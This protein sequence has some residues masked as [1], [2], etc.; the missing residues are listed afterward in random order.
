[1]T[2]EQIARSG[3]EHALQTALFCWTHLPDTVAVFP[4]LG[5]SLLF[6]VPNGGLRDKITAGK[7]KASGV[8]K[9]VP[10]IFL[11][12]A[13]GGWFGFYIEMKKLGEKPTKEQLEFKKSVEDR[14][15]LWMCFD[16][17]EIARDALMH[18]MTL[19]YTER[20]C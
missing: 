3:T 12:I 9:G 13:K 10:D 11:S 7:L 19:P 17:W 4:E 6:A 18:Y 5:T 15:Y 20:R 14:G 8:K 16:S 2:P 1:M